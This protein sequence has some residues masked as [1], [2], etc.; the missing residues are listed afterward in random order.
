M[1]AET[2]YTNAY[3]DYIG[4]NYD[5]AMQEF[6]DYLKYF[7]T[8]QFAPNAQYYVGDIFYKRKDYDNAIQSL[9][10]GAGAFLRQPQDART[11]T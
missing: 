3:R 2:A 11:R 1:Q 9:R 7:P 8:T 6:T 5:L 10:R 4:G